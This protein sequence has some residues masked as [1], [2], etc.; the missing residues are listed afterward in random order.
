[1]ITTC[2]EA[3]AWL[4]LPQDGALA[5]AEVQRAFKRRSLT[6][7]P[8]KPGGSEAA[9]HATKEARQ[10]LVAEIEGVAPNASFAAAATAEVQAAA[11]AAAAIAMGG[12]PESQQ[13]FLGALFSELAG[14]QSAG[15]EL[16][17]EM[18][19]DVPCVPHWQTPRT[20]RTARAGLVRYGP[21]GAL[22]PG[23]AGSLIPHAFSGRSTQHANFPPCPPA[24]AP[25]AP[26]AAAG[27]AVT[28]KVADPTGRLLLPPSLNSVMPA[29]WASLFAFLLEL[30]RLAGEQHAVLEFQPGGVRLRRRGTSQHTQLASVE[31]IVSGAVAP[32]DLCFPLEQQ[33]RWWG[34]W[35][36]GGGLGCLARLHAVAGWRA[37]RMYCHACLMPA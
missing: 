36:R 13:E 15:S 3:R 30:Q 20:P 2:A 23:D 10:V 22:L 1:M 25:L 11:A 34:C 18:R 33:V 26:L 37:L 24:A 31:D 32:G 27:G 9:F 29:H 21:P 5:L 7:H 12:T 4:G 17:L 14:L 19:D 6:A 35:R 8:D 28:T 16:V